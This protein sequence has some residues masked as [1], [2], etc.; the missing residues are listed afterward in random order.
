MQYLVFLVFLGVL[1][2]P[3][4]MSKY[5][6]PFQRQRYANKAEPQKPLKIR[7][8]RGPTIFDG[9]LPVAINDHVAVTVFVLS[10]CTVFAINVDL[11]LIKKHGTAPNLA[12]YITEASRGG[13]FQTFAK[14]LLA[15]HA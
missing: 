7:S 11:Y 1:Q 12:V 9:A 4:Q 14:D 8:P 3:E 5:F 6:K 10:E 2:L 13:S 15:E